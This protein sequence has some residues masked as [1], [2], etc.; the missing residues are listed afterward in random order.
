MAGVLKGSNSF[1]VVCM[2]PISGGCV[3]DFIEATVAEENR[4]T[5]RSGL[6]RERSQKAKNLTAW[7]DD[8][9]KLGENYSTNKTRYVTAL[10]ADRVN[11]LISFYLHG[12]STCITWVGVI[13]RHCYSNDR[14]RL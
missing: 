2:A 4:K 11:Y 10:L 5:A 12:A 14:R 9:K 6:H 13:L 7:K 8:R 3:R 1:G